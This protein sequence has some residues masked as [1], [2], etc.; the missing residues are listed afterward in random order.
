MIP[1][2]TEDS[3]SA[4][5]R[6]LPS[7]AETE[8]NSTPV[9]IR[10]PSWKPYEN[11][12]PLRPLDEQ[13]QTVEVWR[14]WLSYRWM[15]RWPFQRRVF[16]SFTLGEILFFY[17]L[18]ALAIAV[19]VLA[20]LGIGL[21]QDVE[22]T[23]TLASIPFLFTFAAACHNSLFTFLIGIPFERT[24]IYHRYSAYVGLVLGAL[25][26][27][28]Y[29]FEESEE[30]RRLGD[31]HDDD[32]NEEKRTSGWIL[33]AA[34]FGLVAFSV[35]PIRR[36][37]FEIFYRL[38]VI[39]FLVVIVSALFHGAT[40]TYIGAGIWFVD[41]AYRCVT[42]AMFNE[43]KAT[44]DVLP[45]DVIKV[46]FP[47]GDRWKYKPGQYVFICVPSL[48]IFQ[49]HPFSI[50]SSP[51][52]DMVSLHIR[53]L[54]G[55]TKALHKKIDESPE[56][57]MTLGILFEGPHG[58]TTVNLDDQTYQHVL[59]VSGGI[60]ITPMHSIVNSLK[61]QHERGRPLKK[62]YNVWAV[63]DR[64]M[65][66]SVYTTNPDINISVNS[67][68]KSFQPDILRLDSDEELKSDSETIFKTRLYLTKL[69]RD[70]D[71]YPV[72]NISPTLQPWLRFG[73]PNLK[74]IFQK[75][76]N[77]SGVQHTRVAVL[78]CGPKGLINEVEKLARTQSNSRVTFDFH[79]ESFEF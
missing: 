48:S 16:Y 76:C 25:H 65:I 26:G 46:S 15:L 78:T 79:K 44:F 69:Q 23:G 58:E 28:L 5:V 57:S 35:W 49:W 20:Y 31:E 36:Y 39:F 18:V 45:A 50:S 14:Q 54:G 63:R 67:L 42:A 66:T 56:K 27:F 53:V 2:D 6:V 73:R 29:E 43:Q 40:F 70:K 19:G 60:G 59:L 62:V 64:F 51:A 74:E 1:N 38:H 77:D 32:E 10:K 30:G 52:D 13:S 68:P 3:K 7:G 41:F 21:E 22:S 75:F 47:K 12:Y 4:A 72:A 8:A 71:E 55:W 24:I 34:I 33:Q 17:P 11:S 61:E 9:D 37:F